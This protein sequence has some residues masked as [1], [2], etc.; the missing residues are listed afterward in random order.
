MNAKK[1]ARSVASSRQSAG[2]RPSVAGLAVT[3]RPGQAIA[4]LLSG[5]LLLNPHL[6]MA[7]TADGNT[8][9][10]RT[11]DR[12]TFSFVW[13]NDAIAGTDKNYTNGL[14]FAWLGAQEQPRGMAKFLTRH[15]LRAG[16]DAKIRRGFAF[17]HSIFTPDNIDTAEPLPDQHPYAAWLY[18]EYALLIERRD[19]VDRLSIQA[20][21][22]GPSA[23]GE[24]LQNEVHSL[25]DSDQALGWDN[26]IP[27]E[28]GAVLSYDRKLRSFA[29]FGGSGLGVDITPSIG[30]S[31]GNVVTNARLGLMAR[32]GQDLRNDFG[33]PRIRPAL[34]GAGFFNPRDGASAYLF[35][36]AELR[37]VAHNIFLDGSLF[38]DGDPSVTRKPLVADFQ[39]GAVLQFGATQFSLTFVQRSDEFEE[40]VETQRFGALSFATR[41]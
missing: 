22:V 32:F 35:A 10:V 24:W 36:G 38:R 39:V 14:R 37:A 40:Q 23:G 4:L 11:D 9:P 12:A 31:L 3:L 27:D 13:E 41:F 8:A 15:I 2:W 30:A 26:Q 19:M 7:D 25:I 28:F 29:S 34:A 16:A 20:G 18:G 17:G 33:P 5:L 21:V 6:S 1:P